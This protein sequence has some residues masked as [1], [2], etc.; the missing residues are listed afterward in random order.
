[1][2]DL[3]SRKALVRKICAAQINKTDEELLS[4]SE[5]YWKGVNDKQIAV[6]DA[7]KDVP[8]AYDV[9]KV[10][11]QLNEREADNVRISKLQG[12]SHVKKISH[13]CRSDEDDYCIRLVKGAVKDE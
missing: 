6:M 12:N 5:D 10:V 9:D 1:M 3:I 4:M 13:I 7:I 8:S 11:E 2:D